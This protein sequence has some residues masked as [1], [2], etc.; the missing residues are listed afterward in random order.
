VG[1]NSGHLWWL[2]EM[3]LQIPGDV[4]Y[5]NIQYTESDRNV[6]GVDPCNSEI[7][8]KAAEH[9]DFLV[10]RRKVGFSEKPWEMMAPLRWVPGESLPTANSSTSLS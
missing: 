8:I 4:A 1:F 7:Q 2:R 3:G 9:L 6:A 10:R 5:A